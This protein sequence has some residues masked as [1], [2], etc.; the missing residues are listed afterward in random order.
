[1]PLR[2]IVSF[3]NSPTY[4]ISK[5][6]SKR[7]KMAYEKEEIHSIENSKKV[8]ERLKEITI[9]NKTKLMSLDIKDMYTNIPIAKTV[10]IIKK[11]KLSNVEWKNEIIE[12]LELCLSQN[13]FRFNNKFY[14]QENGLPM[15][16]PL[17]PL[18]AEIFMNSFEIKILKDID[19]ERRIKKWIR[20]VDDILIVWE[21][22]V[23]EFKKFTEQLNN[24]EKTIKFQEE[25][26]GLEINFLDINIKIEDNKLKFDIYRKGT[27]SDLIIP[28]ESYHPVNYKMAA[29]NSF[30]YRA[31]NYLENEELK[32]KELKKIQQIAKNNNYNPKIINRI[33]KKIEENKEIENNKKE[34][35]NEEK[36]YKGA[37]TYIGYQTKMLQKCFEKYEIQI[38]IK[39]TKNVFE[40][41]KNDKTE[42]IPLTEKSGVYKLKCGECNKIYL[43]E[44]GR[45]FKI[46]MNE[47]AKGE[48]VRVTNSLYARHFN[49]SGHKFIN[50]KEN[51]E[52]IKIENNPQK[53][54]LI[55]ELEILKV[56]KEDKNKLMNIKVD[57]TNEEIFYYILNNKQ[58]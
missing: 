44:T 22:E 35:T 42:E 54:K 48:G 43:G 4:K 47:H 51:M 14:I 31:I 32:Q 34:K 7:I 9:T 40:Y 2:P 45:K 56:K 49:E 26:G 52:I 29:L 55:E 13:Y 41:I 57:F 21:G 39:K 38:G 50:P 37:I 11:N 27:Y 23:N 8:I 16:S 24:I 15:G 17:S 10:E 1:M 46:R 53:R 18:M 33:V 36:K 20:Y 6:I 12:G 30:C 3:I 5:E 28:Q 25:I 58:K 19:K